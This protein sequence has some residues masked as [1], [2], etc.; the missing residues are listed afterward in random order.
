MNREQ[1]NAEAEAKASEV[2][3]TKREMPDDIAGWLDNFR[4]L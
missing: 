1:A 2:V 4:I 3:I